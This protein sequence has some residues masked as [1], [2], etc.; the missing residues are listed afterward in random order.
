M[1]VAPRSHQS[2]PTKCRDGMLIQLIRSGGP[3]RG[4]CI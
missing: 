4:Q 3:E 2:G 1:K